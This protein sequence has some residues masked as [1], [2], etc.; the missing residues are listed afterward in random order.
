[1]RMQVNCCFR[2]I[3]AWLWNKPLEMSG[4]SWDPSLS[5]KKPWVCPAPP[6]QAGFYVSY[7]SS[8][9]KN[10]MSSL[11]TWSISPLSEEGDGG[12]SVP[13]L[14]DESYFCHWQRTSQGS[15]T[16]SGFLP[17]EM[18]SFYYCPIWGILVHFHRDHPRLLGT[19]LGWREL[20]FFSFTIYDVLGC[21]RGFKATSVWSTEVTLLLHELT[22]SLYKM[23]EIIEILDWKED[24]NI[25]LLCGRVRKSGLFLTD[26]CIICS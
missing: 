11:I 8:T 3:V 14:K 1:M 2:F 6:S 17:L 22:S 23:G 24:Q 13:I 26:V 5:A 16:T 18:L 4:C 9:T 15:H 20:K 25:P 19:V 10:K 12:L 21:H 7:L